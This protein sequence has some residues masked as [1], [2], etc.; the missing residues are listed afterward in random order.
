MTRTK[1]RDAK[2]QELTRPRA[3]RHLRPSDARLVRRISEAFGLRLKQV[4]REQGWKQ[5]AFAKALGVSRTTVSNIE[6]GAQRVFLD[7]A[8]RASAILRVSLD[9]LLPAANL[10]SDD[11][12]LHAPADA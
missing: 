7:Q 10:L 11:L 9:E 1:K 2:T 5:D 3:R 12:I 6:R 4:R 8:Y